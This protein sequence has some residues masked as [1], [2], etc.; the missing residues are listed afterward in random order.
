MRDNKKGQITIFIIIAIIIVAA[1]I[2]F[3]VVRNVLDKDVTISEFSPIYE[4]FDSC[5]EQT[6]R[7]ALS[8]AG[9]QAGYLQPPDFIPGSEYSPFSNQLQFVGIGV[10]YWYY[11]SANGV[12]KEQVPSKRQIENQI[13]D[14]LEI[15]LRNCD[16]SLFRQQGHEVNLNAPDVKV[17]SR[18]IKSTHSTEVQSK[19]GEFYN[20]ALE[21]YDKELQEVFLEDLS[22][23]VMYNYA[24]VTGSEVSCSP[25]I[26]NPSE[27]VD[28]IKSGLSSNVQALK[29]NNGNYDLQKEENKYFVV[30]FETKNDVRFLYQKDWP[31]KVEIWPAENS[32]L[33]AEPVGLEQGLGILGFCYVPYHFVYDIYYPVLIQ[34]YDTEEIFQFPVS[35]IVD[36]SVPRNS[37]DGVGIDDST[38]LN[39]FCNYKNTEVEVFTFDSSLDPVEADISFTCLNEKCNIGKTQDVGGDA[40]L[41]EDF[42]QCINGKI[43]AKAEGYVTGSVVKSTNEEGIAN[44]VLDKLH[45]LDL[46]LVVGGLPLE[47]RDP[48]GLAVVNFKSEKYTTTV[49]YPQIKKVELA[50]GLYNVSVQ[51]FS[52]SSLTIPSSSERQCIQVDSPGI[53][54]FFG[55]TNEECFNIELPAQT[56]DNALSGGGESVEFLFESDLKSSSEVKVSVPLLPSPTSFDQLQQ[57]YEL[58]SSQKLGVELS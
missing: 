41:I 1:L 5:I 8:I 30:D 14:F 2:I 13:A 10:P 6:T 49:V 47:S 33:I 4:S 43:E 54:G 58:L 53:L 7:E 20:I 51:V 19:F 17:G 28:D 52:G 24:P 39:E 32:L 57:N 21:L 29:I 36:K 46:D 3:F 35:V 37:L 45:N 50:E 11:L 44:I 23:D 40:I 38:S 56:L 55:K 9:T 42:P 25:L 12:I 22:V 15:E 34:I 26:W 16:F 31:T 18:E 48:K 27:V